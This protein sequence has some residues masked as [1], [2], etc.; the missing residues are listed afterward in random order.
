MYL[1]LQYLMDR[2]LAFSDDSVT[3]RVPG[4][5]DEPAVIVQ[6]NRSLLRIII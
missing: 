4:S 3:S 1:T 6:R 5:P 2:K